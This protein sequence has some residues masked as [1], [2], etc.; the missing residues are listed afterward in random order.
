MPLECSGTPQKALETPGEWGTFLGAAA[1]CGRGPWWQV[2]QVRDL[3]GDTHILL[4]DLELSFLC[5]ACTSN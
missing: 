3:F 2:G 4:P 1:V 5:N